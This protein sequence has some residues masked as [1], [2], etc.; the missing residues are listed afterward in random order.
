M[1]EADLAAAYHGEDADLR[2]VW[3]PGSGMT[4]RRLY[5]LVVGLPPEARIWAKV[6]A[7]RKAALVPKP[8]LIRERQA[9]YAAQGH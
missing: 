1:L 4:L 6:E 5:G 2:S 7:A 3:R 8:D 9:H